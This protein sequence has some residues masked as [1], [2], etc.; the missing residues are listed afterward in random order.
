M[1]S[2]RFNNGRASADRPSEKYNA[3]RLFRSVPTSTWSGAEKFLIN[4]QRP[5][6]ERLGLRVFSLDAVYSARLLR[7]E[8]TV[9]CSLP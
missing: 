1:A 6:V 8:A 3:P 5:P 4:Q 9:R 7:L 2:A